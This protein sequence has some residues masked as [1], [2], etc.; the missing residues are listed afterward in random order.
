MWK[1]VDGRASQKP[2]FW[3][4]LPETEKFLK[5]LQKKFKGVSET[6]LKTI[7]GRFGGTYAHW[8]IAMEYARYLDKDFAIWCNDE[9]KQVFE[10][11]KDPEK[12]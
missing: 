10:F 1:A 3:L 4:R 6:P 2:Y 12:V 9:I 7:K 5:S 8:Q 11:K